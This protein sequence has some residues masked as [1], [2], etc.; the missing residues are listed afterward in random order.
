MELVTSLG[1][2]IYEKENW[3]ETPLS[4]SHIHLLESPR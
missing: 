4:R 1:Y 2:S 3:I